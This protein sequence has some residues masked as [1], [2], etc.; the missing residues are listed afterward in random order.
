MGLPET[1]TVSYAEGKESDLTVNDTN[2]A[3]K[4]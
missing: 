2:S 3:T 4:V 1:E